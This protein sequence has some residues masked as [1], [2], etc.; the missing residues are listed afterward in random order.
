[1]VQKNFFKQKYIPFVV[2][3][4]LLQ[5]DYPKSKWSVEKNQLFWSGI[6]KPSPL[7][8]EYQIKMVCKSGK[9]P[10]VI[11][12]GEKIEGIEKK[13]FPHHYRINQEKQ[14][15]EL[16]LHLPLEFNYSC[17]IADTII[18]WIQEWLYY[19]EIWLTTGEWRGGGHKI[20]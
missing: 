20:N 11:L 16:C 12:Y 2:Q 15:V 7:S 3:G 10:K 6:I 4:C 13:D 5:K 9:K 8:R 18:P 19:Y 17:S 14:E 1:M